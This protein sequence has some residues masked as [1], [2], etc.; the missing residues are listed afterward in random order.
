MLT[1]TE[2]FLLGNPVTEEYIKY[3]KYTFSAYK[4][5]FPHYRIINIGDIVSKKYIRD[6]DLPGYLMDYIGEQG[7]VLAIAN[8]LNKQVPFVQLR[9]L[10]RKEFS[11]YGSQSSLLYNL[12]FLDKNFK[13]GD[14]LII[15]EGNMDAD[16]MKGIYNN[17]VATCTAGLTSKQLEIVSY[18]TNRVI[19]AY[20]N[21]KAGRGAYKRDSKL[22]KEKGLDV[23]CLCQYQGFKDV[24]DLM[25]SKF[26]G[27]ERIFQTAFNYYYNQVQI[28]I[29]SLGGIY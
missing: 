24:G 13:Y 25:Q 28:L 7:E 29:K 26:E 5:H 22:L 10:K 8:I 1:P 23:R 20:D 3:N 11:V 6:K 15:V 17:T 4:Y 21:D 14:I 12:G 9:A 27:D 16:A 2:L 18:L 19:L